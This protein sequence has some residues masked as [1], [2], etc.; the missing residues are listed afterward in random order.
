MNEEMRVKRRRAQTRILPP[1][2][3]PAIT[4]R[5]V[6]NV[7]L[8]CNPPANPARTGMARTSEAGPRETRLG[9]RQAHLSKGRAQ[10][11]VVCVNMRQR[12]FR[13]ESAVVCGRV[14]HVSVGR[15]TTT[16]LL[17]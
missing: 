6:P 15:G 12:D 7:R 1:V 17:F 5:N 3:R 4:R 9:A 13:I 16:S 14:E 11:G 10:H 2:W 8:E